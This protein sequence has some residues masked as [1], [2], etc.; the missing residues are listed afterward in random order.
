MHVWRDWIGDSYVQPASGAC[1]DAG[2]LF[3]GE[4]IRCLDVYDPICKEDI[5]H[6]GRVNMTDILLVI[7]AFGYCP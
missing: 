7:A 6:D 1:W 3:R 5:N 4:D 2:G